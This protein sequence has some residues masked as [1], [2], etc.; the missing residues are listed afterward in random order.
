MQEEDQRRIE[1]A[2]QEALEQQRRATEVAN[3]KAE[4]ER[5]K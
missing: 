2:L 4:K 1:K 5:I 3:L